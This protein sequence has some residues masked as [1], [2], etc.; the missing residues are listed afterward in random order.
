M[1]LSPSR[2]HLPDSVNKLSIKLFSGTIPTHGKKTCAN[3]FKIIK[4]ANY[5]E[6]TTKHADFL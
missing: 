4:I 2:R 1:K 6:E 5:I 3:S